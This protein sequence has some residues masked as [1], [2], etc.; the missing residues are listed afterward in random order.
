MKIVVFCYSIIIT[1]Y[2][3]LGNKW[4]QENHQSLKYSLLSCLAPSQDS[5][6]PWEKIKILT[7]HVNFQLTVAIAFCSHSNQILYDYSMSLKLN[8]SLIEKTE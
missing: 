5:T 7:R 1:Y 4:C 8:F 2:V 6:I 3:T